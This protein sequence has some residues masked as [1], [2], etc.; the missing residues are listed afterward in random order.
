[1]HVGDGLHERS[2]CC[3][4]RFGELWRKDFDCMFLLL[5][6]EAW[7]DSPNRKGE[8]MVMADSVGH[9]VFVY[10][11]V[12]RVIAVPNPIYQSAANFCVSCFTWNEVSASRSV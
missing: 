4:S 8:R 7:L 5:L 12:N 6:D 9:Q 2:F 10:L 11:R 1:M 3:L